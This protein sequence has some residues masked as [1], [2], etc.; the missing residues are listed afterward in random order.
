MAIYAFSDAHGCWEPFEQ[1]FNFIKP[2]DKV[3]C[4]GDCGDR[5][6][7]GWKI[8]ETV[9][10]DNR[11]IYLMGNHEDMLINTIKDYFY[12]QRTCFG[13]D[14]D[15]I[16]FNLRMCES[17]DILKYNG[18]EKTFKDWKK[19]KY[20]ELKYRQLKELKYRFDYVNKQGQKIILTHAGFTPHL[21]DIPDN[22]DLIWSRS[23]FNQKWDKNFP[24]TIIVHGHTPII[25]MSEYTFEENNLKEIS[26]S[27]W[28]CNKHKVN[29]DYCTIETGKLIL[30]NLDTWEEY[31]FEK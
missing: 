26:E 25:Y 3:I 30:L 31:I 6:K 12:I 10:N 14:E 4:L 9:L 20:K 7:D 24:D 28:Y 16:F 22:E 1:L 27:Y 11:F 19:A 23:H 15:E 21:N 8:I 18:G 5:G 2:E 13:S 29:I 17:Y